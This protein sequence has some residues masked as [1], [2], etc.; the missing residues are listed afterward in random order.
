M[1][2]LGGQMLRCKTHGDQLHAW[3]SGEGWQCRECLYG[4]SLGWRELA[5]Y[6]TSRADK[7]TAAQPR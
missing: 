7:L 2:L 1:S 4:P 6:C 3:T 5:D